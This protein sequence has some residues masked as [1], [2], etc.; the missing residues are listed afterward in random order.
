MPGF[1]G[2]RWKLAGTFFLITLLTILAA[3]ISLLAWT[4]DNYINSVDQ[5]LR[6]ESLLIGRLLLN[7]QK[8]LVS[9]SQIPDLITQ[10]GRS[11][12]HRITVIAPDGKV[13]IDSESSPSRMENHSNRPEFREAVKSGYGVTTRYSSTLR[14]R[15]LYV[16][17]RF[18]PVENPT[19]VVRVS[20]PLSGL[21]HVLTSIRKAFLATAL[22]AIILAAIASAKL[23]A[24]ITKTIEEVSDKARR[25]AE[26]DLTARASAPKTPKDE[27]EA[28]AITFNKMADQLES[29]VKALTEKQSQ[30]QAI[31]EKTGNG[32]ILLDSQMR[33][34][35][36]NP[37]ACR[38]L[39]VSSADTAGKT[40]IEGTLSHELAALVE[41][42]I[43]TGE[44]AALDITP[45]SQ[46]DGAV[47]SYVTPLE[48]RSGALVVLHDITAA[49]QLD[50]VRRDFV[51]NVS[52][53]LRNPLASIKAMAE[54]IMLRYKT[55]P[56][57]PSQFAKSI[58][59]EADR[60]T[61]LAEDLLD[62]ARIESGRRV[63]TPQN[64]DI[65]ELVSAVFERLKP[66]A[67]RKS[68]KLVS[69]VPIGESVFADRDAL[70][71]VISNLVDNAVKY[72]NDEGTV[73][74]GFERVDSNVSISV[75]DTGIGMPQ[76]DLARIFERFYRID[77][78]RSRESGGTGLGLSIVKHLTE[79][80]GGSIS[81][82]SK[83]NEGT[84]FT[85][86]I[87]QD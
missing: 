48:S 5:D 67:D 40:V 49:R 47:Q 68:V 73:T 6:S 87:P 27:T 34:K 65:S 82:T 43:R 26:G 44:P 60:M 24:N 78:A 70:D 21:E 9:K 39:S 71:Q 33:I 56:E 17:T 75:T 3:G 63:L 37:A 25:L 8:P 35:M 29:T 64:V 32:L 84:T 16:A 23:A 2:I 86:V 11:F 19:G 59:D 41:R 51:A 1:Y 28:L 15:M 57:A 12:N 55:D 74:V 62:L 30:M 76:E 85:V 66:S 13:L 22:I 72:N 18:G 31:F 50:A 81:V 58:V 77:K 10:M 80:M 53:E 14:V 7:D 69:E 20:E 36:I 45:P 52:H 42:V 46:E 4:E 54:T 38:M 83:I 61:F 79:S